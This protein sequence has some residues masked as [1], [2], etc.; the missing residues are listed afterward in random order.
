MFENKTHAT[1]FFSGKI[2]KKQ[3]A[4]QIGLTSFNVIIDDDPC[5]TNK[6][7]NNHGTC[8]KVILILIRNQMGSLYTVCVTSRGQENSVNMKNHTLTQRNFF[9][10][11]DILTLGEIRKICQSATPCQNQNICS[12]GGICLKCKDYDY[13]HCNRSLFSGRYCEKRCPEICDKDSLCVENLDVSNLK[14]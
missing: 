7:C 5:D 8:M 6:T 1:D 14:K 11:H 9:S 13:C 2:V 3:K 12:D 10:V 4:I